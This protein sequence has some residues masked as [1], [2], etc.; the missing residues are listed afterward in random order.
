MKDSIK[1]VNKE[2]KTNKLDAIKRHIKKMNDNKGRALPN[3]SKER[4]YE[5]RLK[6]VAVEGSNL[7]L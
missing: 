3:Y 1:K 4:N 5:R 7:F 2:I 6:M